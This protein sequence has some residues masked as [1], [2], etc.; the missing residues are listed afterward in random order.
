MFKKKSWF[1]LLFVYLFLEISYCLD[2]VH[3]WMIYRKNGISGRGS[4]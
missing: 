2:S 4:N 3:I 1:R